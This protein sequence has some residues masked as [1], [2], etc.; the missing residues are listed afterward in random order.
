MADDQ[1]KF[2]YSWE[3]AIELLRSDP[4]HADL[5]FDSYLTRDLIGN[6]HRFAGSS[7]FQEVRRLLGELAPRARQL[8][9]MPGGNGIATYAF[10]AAGF[11]VTTVEPN[12]SDSVGRGAISQVL[13]ADGLQARIVDAWGESLPFEDQ[14]FDVV[15]VRQGLHHAS[16]LGK[17]L[18][19]IARVLR[20]CGMVMACREHVVDNYGESLQAF[21]ASQVDHQL[22]GGENAFTLSDYCSAIRNAGLELLRELGP[23]DSVINTYP[24]T[25]ESYRRKILSS[26][27]GRVLKRVLPSTAVVALGLM[28]LRRQRK[29]GRLYTFIARKPALATAC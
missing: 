14:S 22:Y 19:E 29:A 24:N 6:C 16:D 21:L 26:S 8:L 18:G 9:D 17:M 27:A 13:D 3:E 23:Y 7:E 25:E 11:A 10:S 5:I 15:Y 12:A 4:N 1:Q 28:Q 2:R 20:P